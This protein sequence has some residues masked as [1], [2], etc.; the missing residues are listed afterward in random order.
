M[1]RLFIFSFNSCR[2]NSMDCSPS[3]ITTRFTDMGMCFTFNYNSSLKSSIAGTTYF[4]NMILNI[5]RMTYF[6]NMIL[7]IARMTYTLLI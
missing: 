1:K 3:Y 7:N 6:V 5:A 4:V 2:W